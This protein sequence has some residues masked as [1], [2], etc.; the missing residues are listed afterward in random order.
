LEERVD[1]YA[2]KPPF[3]KIL[4]CTLE[5]VNVGVDRTERQ[6]PGEAFRRLFGEV[7]ELMRLVRLHGKR[8]DDAEGKALTL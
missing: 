2:Q 4:K 5:I 8:Q 3:L 1:L 6:Q 7:V